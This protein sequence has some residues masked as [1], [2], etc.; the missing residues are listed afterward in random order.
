MANAPAIPGPPV[1]N[2]NPNPPHTAPTNIPPA[3]N[4][5]VALPVVS[6]SAAFDALDP[7][8]SHDTHIKS[9]GAIPST[10]IH[11]G[12]FVFVGIG[13]DSS[14]AGNARMTGDE[15]ESI[16]GSVEAIKQLAKRA[17]QQAEQGM[18]HDGRVQSQLGALKQ[19]LA[20]SLYV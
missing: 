5:P 4:V 1:A 14:S 9:A 12:H 20:G 7:P 16:Q 13:M 18:D 15:V 11:E 6:V 2:P 10:A 19:K 3:V 8:T 17:V